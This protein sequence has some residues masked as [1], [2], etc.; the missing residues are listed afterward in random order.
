MKKSKKRGGKK[1]KN[2]PAMGIGLQSPPT[3]PQIRV[4]SLYPRKEKNG[5]YKKKKKTLPPTPRIKKK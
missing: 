5:K 2:F 3:P 4:I 1:E